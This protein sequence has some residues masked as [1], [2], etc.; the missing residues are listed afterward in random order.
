MGRSI[1]MVSEEVMGLEEPFLR[2]NAKRR[3]AMRWEII[4]RGRSRREG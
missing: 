3:K 2:S 1:I 4:K